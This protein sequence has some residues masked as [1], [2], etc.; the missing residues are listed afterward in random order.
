M[1]V[2]LKRRITTHEYESGSDTVYALYGPSGVVT[3]THVNQRHHGPVGIHS[4]RPLWE[5]HDPDGNRCP[6][7]EAACHVDTGYL[8]GDRIGKKWDA[9][10]RD[11][12]VIWRELAE[13][14]SGHLVDG[15]S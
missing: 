2:Q 11:D 14:Y 15:A 12:E 3:W 1:T 6:F 10:G 4:A 13:W 7:L 9:A 8:G 5:G